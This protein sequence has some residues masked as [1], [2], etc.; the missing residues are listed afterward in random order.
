MSFDT[1]RSVAL[2]LYYFAVNSQ[3]GNR[4]FVATLATIDKFAIFN[5]D[6]AHR[7]V[8]RNVKDIAKDYCRE[9][10]GDWH[11]C[12]PAHIRSLVTT[13]LMEWIIDKRGAV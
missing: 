4:Y 6:A 5:P 9:H 1:D 11:G 13:L 10:G 12:F 2:E 8:A 3:P 7:L